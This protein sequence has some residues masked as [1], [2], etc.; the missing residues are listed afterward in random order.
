[1]GTVV[2]ICPF[3][4]SG[5]TCSSSIP[6]LKQLAFP[7]PLSTPSRHAI[8]F[9]ANGESLVK[10]QPAETHPALGT[11]VLFNEN[12]PHIAGSLQESLRQHLLLKHGGAGGCKINELGRCYFVA[13]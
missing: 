4:P 13:A 2:D 8:T 1:M 10:M 12:L 6:D 7:L 5:A 3:A 11:A 9:V